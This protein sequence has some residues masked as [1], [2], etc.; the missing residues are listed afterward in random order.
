MLLVPK[1]KHG[2]IEW[3]DTFE[4]E[5]VKSWVDERN[6]KMKEMGINHRYWAI[7]EREAQY[8]DGGGRLIKSFHLCE[9]KP[10]CRL[11]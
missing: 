10:S 11:I 4:V 5:S 2:D 1:T 7:S 3:D 6:N 9:K 8:C